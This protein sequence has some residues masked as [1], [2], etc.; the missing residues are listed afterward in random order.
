MSL[1]YGVLVLVY[2]YAV[3]RMLWRTFIIMAVQKHSSLHG[4]NAKSYDFISTSTPLPLSTA[5]VGVS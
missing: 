4:N 5:V 3:C 1:V 2:L